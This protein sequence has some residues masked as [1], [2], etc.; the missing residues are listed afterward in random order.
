MNM[1]CIAEVQNCFIQSH[2]LVIQQPTNNSSTIIGMG[3]GGGGVGD[4]SLA[5]LGGWRPLN[6]QEKY[7]FYYY[8]YTCLIIPQTPAVSI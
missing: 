4:Q 6:Q 5:N 7:P 8:I 1:L 3:C 2:M